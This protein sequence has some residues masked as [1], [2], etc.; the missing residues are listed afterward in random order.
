MFSQAPAQSGAQEERKWHGSGGRKGAEE[1]AAE[2]RMCEHQ[3]AAWELNLK[4]PLLWL[5]RENSPLHLPQ[6]VFAISRSIS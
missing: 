2:G 1:E 3:Q 5:E 4:V 6:E